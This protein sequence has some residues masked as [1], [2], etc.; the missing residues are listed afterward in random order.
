MND[1]PTMFSQMMLQDYFNIQPSQVKG[2]HNIGVEYYKRLLYTK[3][4]AK[5]NFKLPEE[6]DLNW[7]RFWLFHF[8]SIGIVYTSKFGWICYPYGVGQRNLYWNPLV[9]TVATPYTNKINNGLI[10][11]NAEI[12]KCFDDYFGFDD[13]INHYA[14]KL[15]QVDKDININLMNSNVAV[16]ISVADK[17]EAELMK[18]V[19]SEATEGNPFVPYRANKGSKVSNEPLE[20][21]FGDVKGNYIVNDLLDAK[22]T[23]MNEFLTDIGINNA[24]TDK[25]ERLI[26][27]EVAANNGETKALINVVYDNIKAGVESIN[28]IAGLNIQVTLNDYVE[29]SQDELMGGGFR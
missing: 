18:E 3:L 7:F 8:G 22:R 15:A 2:R 11:Y 6:W 14:E 28:R 5:F 10:G 17:K 4:Y 25:K 29:V 21:L 1:V 26:T 13:I 19:Y 12:I 20:P 16:A 9:I 27:D 24:N 23:I